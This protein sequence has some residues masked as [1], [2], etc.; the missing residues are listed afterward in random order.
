MQNIQPGVLEIFILTILLI[1]ALIFFVSI[2]IV[3]SKEKQRVNKVKIQEL[4]LNH[5]NDMLR[6]QLEIQEQ[7][8]QN[9]SREI[10]DNIGQKLTLAKLQLNTIDLSMEPSSQSMVEDV[11]KIIGGAI[12]DLSD[13]SRS[14]SSEVIMNSGFIKALEFEINQLNKT[15]LYSIILKI[16]GDTEFMDSGKE[17]LLFRIVQEALSNIMKHS[18]ATEVSVEVHY[19]KT[20][21]TLTINDNG[22][23]FDSESNLNANGLINMAKRAK[24]LDGLFEI[25]SKKGEGTTI[26]IKIPLY[27]STK[28]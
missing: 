14:M 16:T 25:N 7:T 6:S 9:I 13:I 24:M 20:D 28:V 27:E 4:K 2:I 12:R 15:R 26:I 1:V 17:L 10:H 3:K 5:E 21:L 8:F 11:V 18:E 22:K 23:G 19:T